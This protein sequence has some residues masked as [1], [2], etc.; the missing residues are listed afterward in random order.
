MAPPKKLPKTE[1][2]AKEQ[3]LS[4]M[5]SFF[6]PKTKRGRPTKTAS[7]AGRKA[8]SESPAAG[9]AAAAPPAAAA[10]PQAKKIA[11]TRRNWSKGEGLKEM[12]D[13]VAEWEQEQKRPE[14]ERISLHFFAE[15]RNIP[16]TTLQMHITSNDAKRIK[17][18]S[19]VGRKP[20]IG[21]A[22]AEIIADVLIRK[23]RANQGVGV[24]GAIDILEQMHPEFT[25]TQLDQSFRRTVRPLY[26]ERLT[27]LVAVQN[28][29]TKRAAITVPQQFRWHKVNMFL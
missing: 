14:E 10:K 19:S 27:N 5:T 21:G 20:I 25:R 26:S 17:L 16:Y 15:Q 9:A 8:A 7:N 23:D 2:A 3:G 4:G 29:T 1:G 11:V 12:T 6:S 22:S 13:A 28:T 18:G 24:R